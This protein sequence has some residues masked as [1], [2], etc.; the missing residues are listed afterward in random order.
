MKILVT[1]MFDW[2]HVFRQFSPMDGKLIIVCL[3]LINGIGKFSFCYTNLL[4]M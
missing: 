3:Y 1:N 4:S 2:I